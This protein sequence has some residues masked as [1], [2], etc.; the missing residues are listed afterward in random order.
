MAVLPKILRN[1][2]GDFVE[3]QNLKV[4]N[5]VSVK[6]GSLRGQRGEIINIDEPDK[7]NLQRQFSVKGESGKTV[8]LDPDDFVAA[9]YLG[10][11][12]DAPVDQSKRNFMKG[13]VP[14]AAGLGAL[15]ALGGPVAKKSLNDLFSSGALD[16]TL[17]KIKSAFDEDWVDIADSGNVNSLEVLQKNLGYNDDQLAKISDETSL[18]EQLEMVDLDTS[19]MTS[20]EIAQKMREMTDNFM[21]DFAWDFMKGRGE[22]P[23]VLID[24]FKK[25]AFKNEILEQFPDVDVNEINSLADKLF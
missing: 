6:R 9:D 15:G 2:L 25:P 12:P 21:G 8:Y 11:L 7:D 14:A 16:D 10:A 13:A 20:A 1:V 23:A 22:S 18:I 3:K 17:L 5:E 4:G 24:E 19:K